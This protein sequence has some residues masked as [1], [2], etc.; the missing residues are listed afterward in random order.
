MT[1][2]D[3]RRLDRLYKLLERLELGKDLET[4]AALR[5]AI[6]QLEHKET[7]PSGAVK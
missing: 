3:Q 1:Q 7:A 2:L 4:T 6:L 5:W